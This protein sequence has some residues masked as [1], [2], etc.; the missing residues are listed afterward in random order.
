MYTSIT[1][2]I[3]DFML[4]LA[5]YGSE[6]PPNSSCHRVDYNQDGVINLS[7]LMDHLANKPQ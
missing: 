1:V 5:C 2:W 6:L 7:D 3:M 4:L